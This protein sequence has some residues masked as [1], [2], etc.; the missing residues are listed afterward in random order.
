MSS[1]NNLFLSSSPHFTAGLSTQKIMAAVLLALLPE[2]IYGV[3]I[4]GWHALAE[5]AVS[6]V[7]CFVFELLFQKITRQK[8]VV[9]NLSCCVTGVLLALVIPSTTPLWMTCLGA[10]IAVVI[11]KGLF[12]GIGSNVF[13]PAL[14][15]R[16]FMFISFPAALG[17]SWLNPATDAVSSATVLSQVKAGGFAADGDMYLQYFLGNT[18]GCIGE[19]SA[20]LILLSFAFLAF[21]K[22]IDWRAPAAMVATAAL[23]TFVSGGDALFAVLSGGLLFGSV[24]MVTDYATAPVTKK[25]RLVFGFGCGLITFLIRKFGGY[26]EGVMFSILIMNAVAPFLN[27]LAARKYGYGKKAARRQPRKIIQEFDV[28]NAVP[29]SNEKNTE[30]EK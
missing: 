10:F 17:A 12:G 5:I 25:G 3:I 30:A 13:N 23:L 29:L 19:T 22:I 9:A 6:V 8:V 28:A 24:F 27:N 26:P 18:A 16:A 11:A 15:G 1:E 7:S 21:T 4:F 2:C 14:T 20:L